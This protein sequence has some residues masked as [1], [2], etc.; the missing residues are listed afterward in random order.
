MQNDHGYYLNVGK[1]DEYRL[2]CLNRVYNS[3]TQSF[4]LNSGLREGMKVLE[5][6]CGTGIMTQW[7][8]DQVSKTG[9]V[10]G[11]DNN[12]EQLEIA[13]R[14]NYDK[15]NVSF[16]CCNVYDLESLQE[17]YDFV[18]SRFVITHLDHPELALEKI[19]STLKPGGIMAV[20]CSVFDTYFSEPEN[21]GHSEWFR[22]AIR[23]LSQN[24]RNPSWGKKILP[25]MKKLG[26]EII[27]TNFFM[28]IAD[29][30]ESKSYFKVHF[31][32]HHQQLIEMNISTE[33]ELQAHY[34]DLDNMAVDDN[35]YCNHPVC[36]M[37][38]GQ[39]E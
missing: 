18:Y 29:S 10:C 19:A 23:L 27:K 24:N 35:V 2:Q 30:R 3:E 15:Q 7:I 34:Q 39:R 8:A 9:S 20:C 26:F 6:G 31:M 22:L 14:N 37:V 11:L 21:H 28:P 17:K 36:M 25:H 38:A 13:A 12:A 4:L 33:S 16:N 1:Q 5:V 32:S